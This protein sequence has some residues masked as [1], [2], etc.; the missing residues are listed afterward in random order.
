[1]PARSMVRRTST[2]SCSGFNAPSGISITAVA[3]ECITRAKKLP[4]G[5]IEKCWVM[6][7][8]AFG[9]GAG[10]MDGLSGNSGGRYDAFPSS[11]A[12]VG[13]WNDAS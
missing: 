5:L 7:V 13:S 1:V 10:A 4:A 12:P 11:S 3:T 8:S 9:I 6:P 2:V